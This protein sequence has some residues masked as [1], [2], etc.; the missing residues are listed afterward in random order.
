MTAWAY[1]SIQPADKRIQWASSVFSFNYTQSEGTNGYFQRLRSIETEFYQHAERTGAFGRKSCVTQESRTDLE[2]FRERMKQD[3][4]API[5]LIRGDW[6]DVS[7]APAE[8]MPLPEASFAAEKTST[9]YV[10]CDQVDVNR[11]TLVMV[12]PFSVEVVPS[13]ASELADAYSAAFVQEVLQARGFDT[14][15][16][17][18]ELSDT[19]A[20]AQEKQRSKRS[21]FTGFPHRLALVIVNLS[22]RISLPLASQGNMAPSGSGATTHPTPDSVQAPRPQQTPGAVQ[23]SSA[24]PRTNGANSPAP[25]GPARFCVAIMEST[26]EAHK[27]LSVPWEDTRS[28][29]SPTAMTRS[30]TDYVNHLRTLQPSIWREVPNIKC[31]DNHCTGASMRYF[32]GASQVINQFCATSLTKAREIHQNLLNGYRNATIIEWQPPR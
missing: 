11:R 17:G 32:F 30:L 28:D 21:M 12:Q 4:V 9:N 7:W 19:L 3:F 23:S 26:D 14:V 31:A 5:M 20:E 8:W 24:P 1:C 2:L 16:P 6:R 18:C 27:A 13:K 10:T 22:T 25:S 29:G 15:G